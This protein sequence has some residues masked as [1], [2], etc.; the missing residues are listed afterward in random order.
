MKLYNFTRLIQKYS[1]RFYFLTQTKGHYESGKWVEGE[2][3]MQEATGAIVPMSE[4]R[5]RQSG[6]VYTSKDRQ[7]YMLQPI[8]KALQGTK[9]CY[10]DCVYSVEAETDYR[11]YADVA[12]YTLKWVSL[13]DKEAGLHV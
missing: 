8:P 10:Q 9:V 7:L 2:P 13:F 5:I 3:I 11:D 6:G 12:V 4:S 1:T